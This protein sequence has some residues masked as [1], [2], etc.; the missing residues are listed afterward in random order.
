M[1]ISNFT[2]FLI[3]LLCALNVNA[4]LLTRLKAL[5][6]NIVNYFADDD[7]ELNID[8]GGSFT[9]RLDVYYDESDTSNLKPVVIF[10]HGGAWII[11]DK[12]KYSKIGTLLVDEGYIGVLPNYVLF[13]FGSI[14]DMVDDVY[15]AIEWTYNNIEKYGGDK[16]KIILSGHSAGAHL[17]ALTLIKS[18]LKMENQDEDLDPLPNLSKLVLFNGPFD[19]DDYDS[20]TNFFTQSEEVDHGIAEKLISKIFRSK[21]IGPTD[22]LKRIKEKSLAGLGVPKVNFFYADNDKLVPEKSANGLITQI[23][24]VCPKT[25]INYIFNQ[26]NGFEHSTLIMGARNDDKEKQKLFMNII[27]M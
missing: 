25:A 9:S 13:P 27:E 12:I 20:I 7:K 4:G 10:V 17:A 26:G 2:T 1:K 19:F 8:Y 22:I 21:D 18:T 24:R 11:G 15:K 14:E 23:R 6:D 5:K 16:T 3:I